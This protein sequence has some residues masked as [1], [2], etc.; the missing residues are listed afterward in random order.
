MKKS[1]ANNETRVLLV[2][3]G[4]SAIPLLNVLKDNGYYVGVCGSKKEDPCH[5]LADKSHLIDYSDVASL[6]TIYTKYKYS[7]LVAGC[8]DVSYISCANLAEKLKIPG[9]DS[10]ET[11]GM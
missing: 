2:D 5:K 8:T 9:F 11:T 7:F 4:F 1:S 10:S 6:E 3:A